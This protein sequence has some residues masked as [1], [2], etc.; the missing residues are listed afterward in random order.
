MQKRSVSKNK[1]AYLNLTNCNAM[2]LYKYDSK[3][4][5]RYTN[6]YFYRLDFCASH[7]ADPVQPIGKN[8]G[9]FKRS[10]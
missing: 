2:K 6:F 10:K 7:N 3:P 5:K 9:C 4:K 1:I 8:R